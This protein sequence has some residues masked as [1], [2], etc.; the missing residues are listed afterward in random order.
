MTITP[1]NDANYS[2]LHELQRDL[3][4]LRKSNHS[5]FLKVVGDG[6]EQHVEVVK[7][8]FWNFVAKVACFFGFRSYDLQEV[9]RVF[10]NQLNSLETSFCNELTSRTKHEM[11]QVGMKVSKVFVDELAQFVHIR[12]GALE[13][14]AKT[15]IIDTVRGWKR[16]FVDLHQEGGDVDITALFSSQLFQTPAKTAKNT[17]FSLYDELLAGNF[18]KKGEV[19]EWLLGSEESE[20]YLEKLEEIEPYKSRLQGTL[21]YGT[22]T[23]VGTVIARRQVREDSN[24]IQ[25][26]QMAK[27]LLIAHDL[28]PASREEKYKARIAECAMELRTFSE[29]ARVLALSSKTMF[30]GERERILEGIAQWQEEF[31]PVRVTFEELRQKVYDLKKQ[32]APLVSIW[33]QDRNLEYNGTHYRL[34]A[35]SQCESEITT[36]LEAL[37]KENEVLKAPS[38]IQDMSIKELQAK[39]AETV[40]HSGQIVH[41]LLHVNLAKVQNESDDVKEQ[42]SKIRESLALSQKE[43]KGFAEQLSDLV[44][45]IHGSGVRYNAQVVGSLAHSTY[46][47]IAERIDSLQRVIEAPLPESNRGLASWLQAFDSAQMAL[48]ETELLLNGFQAQERGFVDVVAARR[49][50]LLLELSAFLRKAERVVL[51][52]DSVKGSAQEAEVQHLLPALKDKLAALDPDA[53]TE[54]EL[55][56]LFE[57][58]KSTLEPLKPFWKE[59]LAIKGENLNMVSLSLAD[60]TKEWLSHVAEMQKAKVQIQDLLPIIDAKLQRAKKEHA[61]GS[62]AF[63]AYERAQGALK[64]DSYEGAS[65]CFAEV[66]VL[67]NQESQEAKRALGLLVLRELLIDAK[68]HIDTKKKNANKQELGEFAQVE[69]KI[70]LFSKRLGFGPAPHL[71]SRSRLQNI[72]KQELQELATLIDHLNILSSSQNIRADLHFKLLSR[73]RR[74]FKSLI[75]SI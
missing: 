5:V 66:D 8:G 67:L 31:D 21:A 55:V 40:Q 26:L 23:A 9:S 37:V 38:P 58:V 44:K 15:A 63:Q 50:A 45:P 30:Q 61:A 56:A 20:G 75:S 17:P 10:Q 52:Q 59:T 43:L 35:Y 60:L 42:I 24:F 34:K 33:S 2:H 14:E 13:S 4:Y 3:A 22:Y 32:M 70:E 16:H 48:K 41:R 47:K 64:A 68:E 39:L 18:E 25:S 28:W 73:H 74:E 27:K 46:S 49:G 1:V 6:K 7:G 62:L 72:T 11:R 36:R 71:F 53:V 12:N 54:K 65:V 57:E 69:K 29:F 51:N 19:V